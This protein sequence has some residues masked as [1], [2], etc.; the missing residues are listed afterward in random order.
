MT[1]NA[2]IVVQ[3]ASDIPWPKMRSIAG[4]KFNCLSQSSLKF[5]NAANTRID[6]AVTNGRLTADQ[7]NTEKTNVDQR[8]DQLVNQ[9][10][11]NRQ[12]GAEEV[13]TTGA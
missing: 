4:A 10:M 2:V 9:A 1:P 12:P 13:D 3:R 6:Q 5:K 11:P 7:A 8:I